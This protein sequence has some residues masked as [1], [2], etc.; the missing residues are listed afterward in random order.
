MEIWYTVNNK[1]VNKDIEG[2]KKKVWHRT[3]KT[4]SIKKKDTV[5]KTDIRINHD[6]YGRMTKILRVNQIKTLLKPINELR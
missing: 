5:S 2:R 3:Y 4:K 6:N 1:D